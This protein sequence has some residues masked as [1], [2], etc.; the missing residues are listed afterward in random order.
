[1]ILRHAHV[2]VCWPVNARYDV[3]TLV[4]SRH[5]AAL[6]LLVHIG[7]NRRTCRREN[8]SKPKRRCM[9]PGARR[10]SRIRHPRAECSF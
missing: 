7:G 10:R 8:L 5:L 4:S 1:L 6:R 3:E 2:G 9:V